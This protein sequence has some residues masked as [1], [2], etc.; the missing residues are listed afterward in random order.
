MEDM[1]VTEK[2]WRNLIFEQ[3]LDTWKRTTWGDEMNLV[4]KA[5]KYIQEFGLELFILY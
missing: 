3:L 4:K 1:R 5:L 2:R